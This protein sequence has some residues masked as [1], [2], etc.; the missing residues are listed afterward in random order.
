MEYRP[1][2]EGQ[3]LDSYREMVRLAFTIPPDEMQFWESLDPITRENSRGYFDDEGKLL[4]GMVII[5]E[6]ALYFG[7]DR[8]IT[9]ALITAVAS[10]PEYRRRGYIRQLFDGMFKEQR[11]TG[12]ALTALYPFYFPFYRGF[13]Y[14]LAHDAARYL[15]KVDQFKQWR[16]AAEGGRFE[17]ISFEKIKNEDEEGIRQLAALGSLYT[18]WAGRNLGAVARTK[19]WWLGKLTHKKE[20]IPAYLYYNAE[21][22][23]EGYI[24]Y[25]FED[26]G[27]WVREMVIH[28]MLGSGRAAQEAIY[29]FIY[30]HDSQAEKA[31]F[32]LPVDAAFAS[33][34]PDPRQAEVK[35]HSGYMLRLLDVE[36]AFRQ[37]SFVPGAEGEFSFTLVDEMVPANTGAY[38]VK[39]SDGRTE[40]DKMPED[41]GGGA[42]LELNEKTLAQL[43]GGY[44]S[45]VHAARTGQLKVARED[46][47]RGMQSAL[48]PS[49]QPAAFM[50]D[51][52]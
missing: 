4:C 3:E 12:V 48:H 46:D 5:D 47:L 33:Q 23:P 17:P 13:G 38:R 14:E 29:G 21:G 28:D 10:P 40:A 49:G 22:E 37:R 45:P 26:K 34:I 1:I 51:D 20:P 36:G 2:E 18:E 43:Y 31:S 41:G 16:K 30:N 6:G 8:P 7:T 9:T 39:V 11:E 42:G 19:R 52:F 24:I 15:V 32:W 27:E 50:N 25:H 44:I 35:L